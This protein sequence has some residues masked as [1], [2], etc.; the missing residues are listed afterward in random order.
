MDLLMA[1]VR[2]RMKASG[3]NMRTAY[4]C[5]VNLHYCR[6]LGWATCQIQTGNGWAAGN[7]GKGGAA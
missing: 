6:S 4:T 2:T 5:A 3:A 7:R 1:L